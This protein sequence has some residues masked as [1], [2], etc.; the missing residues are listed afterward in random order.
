MNES[1]LAFLCALAFY[2]LVSLVLPRPGTDPSDDIA[3]L[4]SETGVEESIDAV[5]AEDSNP[6]PL[7]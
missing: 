2:G 6:A 1:V 7:G 3:E 5:K 4:N